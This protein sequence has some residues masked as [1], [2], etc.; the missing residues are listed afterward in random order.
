MQDHQ[1]KDAHE[2]TKGGAHPQPKRSS[3]VV[4]YLSL[5]CTRYPV[6]SHSLWRDRLEV[7]SSPKS[8]SA[9]SGSNPPDPFGM[10]GTNSAG[11]VIEQITTCSHS[12][13]IWVSINVLCKHP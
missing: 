6:A 5:F 8:D 2:S 4:H 11:T 1:S 10:E 13:D 3:P 12:L 7:A 9:C